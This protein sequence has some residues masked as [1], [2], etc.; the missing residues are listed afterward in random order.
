MSTRTIE[1]GTSGAKKIRLLAATFMASHVTALW[2]DASSLSH[3]LTE[4]LQIQQ[5]G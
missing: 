1:A 2:Y 4:F 3:C 5:G